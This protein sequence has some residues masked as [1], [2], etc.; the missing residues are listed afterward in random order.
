MNKTYVIIGGNQGIGEACFNKLKLQEDR[1]IT[2]TRQP[3]ESNYNMHSGFNAD[4]CDTFPNLTEHTS[5]IDGVIYCPGSITLKP[6]SNIDTNA[7]IQ[8]FNI[9]VLGLVNTLQ[10]CLPLLKNADNSSVVAFSTIASEL[11]MSYHSS[12][13]CSKS[14]LEGLMKSLAAE[15]AKHKIRFNVIAPSIVDTPLAKNILTNESKKQEIAKKHPLKKIGSPDEI[16]DIA[17]FLLSPSSSWMTGQIIHADGGLS[18]I[19][20]I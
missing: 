17:L 12:I 8:D 2:V 20:K 11:G 9:N 15:Y 5:S 1:I 16:A 13:A 19:S 4:V 3:V 6:F 7:F 14:A 10:H 18:S